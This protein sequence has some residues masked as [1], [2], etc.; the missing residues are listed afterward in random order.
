MAVDNNN[1]IGIGAWCKPE[2][3]DEQKYREG[4]KQSEQFAR[5]L[6]RIST[7]KENLQRRLSDVAN[8]LGSRLESIQ[9]LLTAIE[10]GPSLGQTDGSEKN[11]NSV[12]PGAEYSL[13]VIESGVNGGLSVVAERLERLR[14]R[15]GQL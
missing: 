3:F 15:I 14:A 2:V 8:A 4:I 10:G 12:L 9:S 1:A 7:P 11:A 5:Q 13:E 6:D